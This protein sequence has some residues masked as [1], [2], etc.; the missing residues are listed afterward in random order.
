VHA[1]SSGLRGPWPIRDADGALARQVGAMLGGLLCM[2]AV[3]LHVFK[4]HAR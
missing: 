2:G 3:Q 4:E 1:L